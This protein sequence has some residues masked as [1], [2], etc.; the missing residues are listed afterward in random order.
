MK[1]VILAGGIG[2]RLSEETALRPKPP[3]EVG[4]K[5]VR[6]RVMKTFVTYGIWD[7]AMHSGY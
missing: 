7:L 1:P 4:R 3:V 6:W 2:S 5:S